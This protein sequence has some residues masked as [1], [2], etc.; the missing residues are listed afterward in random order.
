MAPEGR[1][2]PTTQGPQQGLCTL[3]PPHS[4]AQLR[5]RSYGTYVTREKHRGPRPPKILDLPPQLPNIH[6][7]TL[8]ISTLVKDFK[9]LPQETRAFPVWPRPSDLTH[10]QQGLGGGGR[11]AGSPGSLPGGGAAPRLSDARG[12]PRRSCRQLPGHRRC[13]FH[14]GCQTWGAWTSFSG[15]GA[16]RD[17]HCSKA[18][19]GASP[20]QRLGKA[21]PSSARPSGSIYTAMAGAEPTRRRLRPPSQAAPCSHALP[22]L[23]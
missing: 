19:P 10:W 9:K 12:R 11:A 18:G 21:S 15:G 20:P 4:L 7:G 5:T 6:I 1:S 13:F 3:T 22:R 16:V 23:H 8:P 14:K 17:G 2:A